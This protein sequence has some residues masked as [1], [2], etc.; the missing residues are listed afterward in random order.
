MLSHSYHTLRDRDESLDCIGCKQ[1]VY[2]EMCSQAS[3]CR[4]FY[5]VV[6]L[7]CDKGIVFVLKVY[8]PLFIVP[9]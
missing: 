5:C 6:V 8:F 3:I 7:G 1:L 4:T 2:L 9:L